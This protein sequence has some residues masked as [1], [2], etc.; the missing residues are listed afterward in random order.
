MPDDEEDLVE[1]PTNITNSPE[2]IDDDPDWS[3]DGTRIVFTRHPVTDNP[4]NSANAEIYV[5]TLDGSAPLR[6]LTFNSEEERGPAWSPDGTRIVYLC[7]NGGADFEICVMNADG[8]DQ[9]ALTNNTIL[10]ATAG[11]SPDGQQIVFHSGAPQLGQLPEIW[12]MNADG[13]DQ[14]QLT[15]TAGTNVIASWGLLRDKCAEDE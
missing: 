9:T 12:R 14:T 5:L 3:P 8:T 4:I 15:S 1:E 10:D 7:R 6:R 11:W 13:T 2:Y